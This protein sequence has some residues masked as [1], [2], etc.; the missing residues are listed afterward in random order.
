MTPLVLLVPVLLVSLTASREVNLHLSLPEP[1][2]D[3]ALSACRY[4]GDCPPGYR[5][6]KLKGWINT[7]GF[8]LI[9]SPGSWALHLCQSLGQL[10]INKH[11]TNFIKSR[12]IKI[13][14]DCCCFRSRGRHQ[15]GDS[16]V[17][18]DHL[19]RQLEFCRLKV[20]QILAGLLPLFRT[21][22]FKEF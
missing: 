18:T 16:T 19:I 8:C 20:N 2:E 3:Y 4:Y 15:R 5:C 13:W 21:L 10:L 17:H 11:Q 7:F 6:A 1:G 14:R 12:Q 9:Q 22:T